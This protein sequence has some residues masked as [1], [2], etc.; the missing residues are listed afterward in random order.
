MEWVS[1]NPNLSRCNH[2]RTRTLK[3][4]QSEHQAHDGYMDTPFCVD[5][6]R[7]RSVCRRMARPKIV[8]LKDV[9]DNIAIFIDSNVSMHGLYNALRVFSPLLPSLS[10]LILY[11][12]QKSSS[13]RFKLPKCDNS[14]YTHTQYTLI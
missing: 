8:L 3:H 6:N 7:K 4:R 2:T 1:N 12:Y 14:A 5:R 13:E 10:E 9:F 11:K